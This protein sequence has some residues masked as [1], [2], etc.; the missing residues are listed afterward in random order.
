MIKHAYWLRPMNPIGYA[1]FTS[2]LYAALEQAPEDARAELG[3]SLAL[4]LS[5]P[6]LPQLPFNVERELETGDRRRA[7]VPR[8]YYP[9][10]VAPILVGCLLRNMI[11]A[12]GARGLNSTALYRPDGGARGSLHKK[13][14]AFDVRLLD[15]DKRNPDLQR[16]L[17]CVASWI[18]RNGSELSVSIGTYRRGLSANTVH[19]D[20]GRVQRRCW[21]YVG[22]FKAVWYG[23]PRD[24]GRLSGQRGRDAFKEKRGS[25]P[26]VV[27]PE[28][29]ID[30]EHAPW[31]RQRLRSDP[32]IA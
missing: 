7:V 6:L 19:V 16:A 26:T 4:D 15:R 24:G 32:P 14:A 30:D 28:A 25:V 12:C 11:A 8:A 29:F 1:T 9:N 23:D 21:T 13:A 31:N 10:T 20:C 22:K 18:Y 2:Y 17:A 3:V 27:A 5:Q